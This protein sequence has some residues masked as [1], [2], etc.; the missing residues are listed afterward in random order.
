MVGFMPP[1][2]VDESKLISQLMMCIDDSEL[3]RKY[4]T[5]PIKS[6]AKVYSVQPLYFSGFQPLIGFLSRDIALNCPIRS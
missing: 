5:N 4:I 1:A 6:I 3:T 2:F